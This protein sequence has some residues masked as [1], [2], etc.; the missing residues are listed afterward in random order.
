MYR[1]VLVA[2]RGDESLTVATT[3]IMRNPGWRNLGET[4]AAR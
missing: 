1:N 3:R 4:L 2:V